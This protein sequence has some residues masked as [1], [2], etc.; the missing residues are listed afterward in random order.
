MLTPLR[1]YWHCEKQS[2]LKGLPPGIC[3]RDRRE[4]GHNADEH[5]EGAPAAGPHAPGREEK[6]AVAH[7]PAFRLSVVYSPVRGSRPEW[8]QDWRALFSL[9][10]R[11][12]RNR[13]GTNPQSGSLLWAEPASC[14]R[15]FHCDRQPCRG[16]KAIRPA[17]HGLIPPKLVQNGPFLTVNRFIL[18]IW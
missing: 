8:G 13:R 11:G 6:E 15:R 16:F 17:D 14:I 1:S 12:E 9:D 5:S 18:G 3:V 2:P 4:G 10:K 7:A